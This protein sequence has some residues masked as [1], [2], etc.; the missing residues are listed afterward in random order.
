MFNENSCTIIVL[1]R[2]LNDIVMFR[3]QFIFL[4]HDSKSYCLHIRNNV[5]VIAHS[6]QCWLG[7]SLHQFG[8]TAPMCMLATPQLAACAPC[9]ACALVEG[10]NICLDQYIVVV[11][12]AHC[13]SNP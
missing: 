12:G 13:L 7:P 2:P 9:A 5:F 3:C 1:G 4:G 11:L 10:N 6:P 8:G